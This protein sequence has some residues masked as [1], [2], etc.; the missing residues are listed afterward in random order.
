M[1]NLEFHYADGRDSSVVYDVHPESQARPVP[2]PEGAVS[3][4]VWLGT[5][6]SLSLLADLPARG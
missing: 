1:I 3:V 4:T 2:V 6:R 5:M